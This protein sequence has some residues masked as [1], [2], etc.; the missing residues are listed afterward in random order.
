MP[1]N[2]YGPNDNYN[3]E[4]SHVLPA[5]LR[6]IHDAKKAGCDE[7]V[8]WG[9]G[10]PQR[11]FMHVD[12]LADALV[13]L[14]QTYNG[15]GHINAGTGEEVTILRL[16]QLAAEVIG[17]KGRFVFDAT[18]PDGTPRKLMDSSRLHAL[19]WRPKIGL[20]EGLTRTVNSSDFLTLAVEPM[21]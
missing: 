15:A 12:D 16:H 2:L 19:G 18:K 10:T 4:S 5:T 17:W 7:V 9:T 13:F 14:L 8:I 20:K 6:K 1:T 11:E 21:E 3:F